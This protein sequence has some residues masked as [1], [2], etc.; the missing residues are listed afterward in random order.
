[1]KKITKNLAV[2]MTFTALAILMLASGL[3]SCKKAKVRKGVEGTWKV[4]SITFNGVSWEEEMGE[5]YEYNGTWVFNDCSSKDNESGLCT[6]DVT[7]TITFPDGTVSDP[8]NGSISYKI[9][10]KGESILFE[11]EIMKIDLSDDVLILTST[12]LD[13]PVQVTLIQ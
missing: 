3:Q 6:C 2:K 13:S 9:L 10:D 5:G 4:Q 7:T 1:M 12:D 8:E 11:E